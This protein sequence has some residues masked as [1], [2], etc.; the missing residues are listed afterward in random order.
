MRRS[1]S[2][3][4]SCP[5]FSKRPQL[6][7]CCQR[8]TGRKKCV[9]VSGAYKD[10]YSILGVSRT[11]SK[12]D[13]KK[14]YR[15]KALQL[16]PDVNKAPDAREKFMECKNAYQEI[17]ANRRS[18]SFDKEP[19]RASG[20]R[21]NEPR[22]QQ[23]K[24]EEFYGLGDLFRDLEQEWATSQG[25]SGEPKGLWEEL[26]DIGEEFVEF[27]EKGIGI[28]SKTPQSSAQNMRDEEAKT[29][30]RA[31]PQDGTKPTRKLDIDEELEELRRKMGL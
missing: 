17:I 5:T 27:L 22:R 28:D 25:T 30:Y 19:R 24:E 6:R 12:S 7:L 2:V 13:V 1:I 26:A 10:P 16:H 3:V 20:T 18:D 8:T 23:E 14:A 11:A 31:A 9:V 21:Q 15:K 4:P 29:R